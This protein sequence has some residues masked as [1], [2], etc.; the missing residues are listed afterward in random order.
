M[1]RF[2]ILTLLVFVVIGWG[3]TQMGWTQK[4][5]IGPPVVFEFDNPPLLVLKPH[6]QGEFPNQQDVVEELYKLL[7]FD[8]N[9]ADVFK[10]YE[11]SVQAAYLNKQDLENKVFDYSGWKKLRF[12]DEPLDY[13]VK[14]VL[15]P[16]GEGELQLNLLVYNLQRNERT[17]GRAYGADPHPPFKLEHLRRAGHRA[18]AYIISTLTNNKVTPITET[19][20]CFVNYNKVKD[21]KELY[22]IDYDGHESSLF[23]LTYYNS[24]TLFPDW[25]PDGKELAYVSF[26]DNWS[27]CFIHTLST[28]KAFP[29]AKF[30][31]TNTTPR[32]F[33]D[34]ENLVLSLS[35]EGN[36]ELYKMPREGTK[37]PTRLTHQQAAEISPDVSP[38]GTQIVF[39][40]D[41]VGSPQIYLMD[42]DG[43]NVKRRSYVERKCD[44]PMW[45]PVPVKLNVTG[46]EEKEAYRIA[47]TGFFDS[48]QADIFSIWADGGG[49]IQHT[50]DE[51]ENLNPTWSPN[52]KYI[53]FSSNMLGTGK[54]EIFITPSNPA[55]RLYNGEKYYRVTYTLP[56]DNLSPAWS[57]Q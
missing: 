46:L 56:G 3:M 55:K 27:D 45:S 49:K 2:I 26:K 43:T 39:T 6:V 50:D 52:G 17:I 10:V 32:W 57:P 12:Q 40:S 1:K 51:W 48:N 19:R 28:G 33:P 16:R 41:R 22:L 25:S 8:L 23:R 21:I 38:D 11:E 54:H 36:A 14:T 18:T 42:V 9:F 44:T 47:F 24:K 29:L 31:G 30:R 4:E 5:I 35:A 7:L 20:F 13:V 15:I 53:A 34:G 37:R